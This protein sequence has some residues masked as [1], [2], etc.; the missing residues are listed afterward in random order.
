MIRTFERDGV[1]FKYPGNWS[2]ESEDAGD[3]WTVTLTSPETAF[4]LV[5]LRPDADSPLQVA[6]EALSALRAEYSEL[7]AVQVVDNLA[8]QPA[9]GHDI[10]FLTLDTPIIGWTR[11][12]DTGRGPLLVLCQSAEYDRDANEPV[13]KA[14]CA[15][16]TVED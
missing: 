14:V 16:L 10:D 3:G 5:S 9:V 4:L 8:G 13:L 2:V 7:E 6:E 12:V 1:S 11:C 15:S